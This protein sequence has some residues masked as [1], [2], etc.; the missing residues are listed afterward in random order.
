MYYKQKYQNSQKRLNLLHFDLI[1]TELGY[2]KFNC[3]RSLVQFFRGKNNNYMREIKLT[4]N[5]VYLTPLR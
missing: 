4:T 3:K 1:R 5:A 2:K